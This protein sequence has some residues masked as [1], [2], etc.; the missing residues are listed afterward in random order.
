MNYLNAPQRI[1]QHTSLLKNA[2]EQLGFSFCGV[3]KA[4]FLA[5]EAPRLEA[6]LAQGKHGDMAYMQ[7]NMDKRLDPR[8]LVDGAKSVVSLL[9]N[10]HNPQTFAPQTPKISQYAFGQDY[11]LVLKPK[12][13]EL[14][15]RLQ[16]AVGEVNFRVFTDSAPVMERAWAAK[17]GLGWI[18]KNTNLINKTSGSFFFLAEII[19]DIELTPDH[20]TTDHCGTCT[21]CIDACPTQALT[22]Y[23]INGSQ[24]ISYFTIENKQDALPTELKGKLDNWIFGCDICQTVC[25]WNRFATP[26]HEPLFAPAPDLLGMKTHDW[27]EL[28]LEMYQKLFKNSAVKRTKFKGLRRNIEFLQKP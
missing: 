5:Q 1:A 21:R 23:G 12:L 6:W 7:N 3:S 15:A 9:Y 14:V 25:P 26:T 24:C 19:C 4:D 8:K 18:G 11:H 22:P 10:Y 17:S 2:A 16:A 27:Q 28:T 20:P 13:F